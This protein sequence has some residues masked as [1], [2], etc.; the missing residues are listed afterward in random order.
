MKTAPLPCPPSGSH[1]ISP[2][3]IISKCNRKTY[4]V[5][6]EHALWLNERIFAG[7][8]WIFSCNLSANMEWIQTLKEKHDRMSCSSW[9]CKMCDFNSAQLILCVIL[10]HCQGKDAGCWWRVL[11]FSLGCIFLMQTTAWISLRLPSDLG[12][13]PPISNFLWSRND[14]LM[15]SN[16]CINGWLTEMGLCLLSCSA[17]YN[18]NWLTM[19]AVWM[20]ACHSQES[21]PSPGNIQMIISDNH[22]Q[23]PWVWACRMH[24]RAKTHIYARAQTNSRTCINKTPTRVH[25]Q[26]A[27]KHTRT[28]HPVL[29]PRL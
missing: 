7:S 1:I 20:E 6:S 13:P 23:R 2:E 14:P 4:N 5:H 9:M 24:I 10:F 3:A 16:Y 25:I 29:A 18:T 19:K 27:H 28:A 21:H 11:L 22:I 26:N 15:T 12:P 17:P 8:K